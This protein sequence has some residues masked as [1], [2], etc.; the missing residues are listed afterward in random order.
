M[1]ISFLLNFLFEN[2]TTITQRLPEIPT[3]PIVAWLAV[4]KMGT[5]GNTTLPLL[6]PSAEFES[7]EFP[8]H[9]RGNSVIFILLTP[10]N[11]SQLMRI[12]RFESI[13]T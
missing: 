9:D 2:K 8:F 7:V 10:P 3:N 11:A 4:V 5:S 6:E 12:F 1:L 13:D